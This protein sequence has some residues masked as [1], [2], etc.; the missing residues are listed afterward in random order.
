MGAI[1][2]EDNNFIE[3]GLIAAD[4]FVYILELCQ[5]LYNSMVDQAWR[6]HRIDMLE[7]LLEGAA[8]FFQGF[9]FN[10]QLV[11]VEYKFGENACGFADCKI[12][13]FF[14]LHYTID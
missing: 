13:L 9:A 5:F 3:G 6:A 10:N 1:N 8:N 7:P 12:I 11:L 14:I 4:I 2:Q